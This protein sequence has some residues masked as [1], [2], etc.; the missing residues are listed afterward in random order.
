MD[1]RYDQAPRDR[2]LYSRPRFEERPHGRDDGYFRRDDGP[3]NRPWSHAR[4][5][6]FPHPP[7]RR[8]HDYIHDRR[9]HHYKPYSTRHSPP[10]KQ[11]QKKVVPVD[12]NRQQDFKVEETATLAKENIVQ[13]EVI[14]TRV[15]KE[16]VVTFDSDGEDDVIQPPPPPPTIEKEELLP[17]SWATH[18][19][20]KGEKYY[21]NKITRESAW[22]KPSVDR[23]SPVKDQQRDSKKDIAKDTDKIVANKEISREIATKEIT[24]EITKEVT[25]EVTKGA[26]N[27]RE[28]TSNREPTNN[29]EPNNNS[30]NRELSKEI[31]NKRKFV[32]PDREPRLSTSLANRTSR[33]NEPHPYA[34]RFDPRDSNSSS[35]PPLHHHE[36][37][38]RYNHSPPPPLPPSERYYRSSLPPPPHRD[39]YYHHPQPPYQRHHHHQLDYAPLPPPPPPRWVSTRRLDFD[40]RD[41]P[42]YRNTRDYR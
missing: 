14:N 40:R 8:P 6:P 5:P 33:P 41:P 15:Y 28:T 39:T 3:Q 2:Y 17:E 11:E 18:V 38:S 24:K 29:R 34:R 36:Y 27:N 25:S 1:R 9:D 30:N 7:Q 12:D 22:E 21:Y 35:R 42:P 10:S 20:E 23:L 37:R 19:S 32:L 4:Y 16:A 31:T 13:E 26:T